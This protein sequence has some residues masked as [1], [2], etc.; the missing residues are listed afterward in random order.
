MKIWWRTPLV[1]IISHCGPKDVIF[2]RGLVDVYPFLKISNT[3][4]PDN[5]IGVRRERLQGERYLRKSHVFQSINIWEMGIFS[6]W[7]LKG[8]CHCQWLSEWLRTSPPGCPQISTTVPMLHLHFH[9]VCFP[10]LIPYCSDH[11]FIFWLFLPWNAS[12][13]FFTFTFTFTFSA[14]SRRFYP[15]RLTLSTFVIRSET[16]YH[17]QYSKDGHRAKCKY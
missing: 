10:Y 2:T 14:F 7:I 9:F 13:I 17:C 12:T 5:S 11:F 1:S 8:S 6:P 15:K 16:I 4:L 3:F